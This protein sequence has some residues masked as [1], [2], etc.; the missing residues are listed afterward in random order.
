MNTDFKSPRRKGIAITEI[1]GLP[2]S[3]GV[4]CGLDELALHSRHPPTHVVSILDPGQPEPRE[5][6]SV[7]PDRL[8]R[9]RFHDAIERSWA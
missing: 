6:A 5:L 1:A 3:A 9:L 4:V 7:S 2:A 8:L